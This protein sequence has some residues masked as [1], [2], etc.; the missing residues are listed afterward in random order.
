MYR[1]HVTVDAFIAPF[2]PALDRLLADTPWKERIRDTRELLDSL[3]QTGVIR[4]H[5]SSDL[6]SFGG[7]S[8]DYYDGV[9]MMR[10][11]SDRLLSW[12]LGAPNCLPQTQSH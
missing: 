11:N 12:V 5:D 1:D 4:F 2:D 6:R 10:K 9:H 3:D 8:A 7:D